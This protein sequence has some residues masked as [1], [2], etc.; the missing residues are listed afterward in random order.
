[1]TLAAELTDVLFL[2]GRV[3]FAAVLGYLALGNLLD[4]EGT[5]GYA[6]SKGA[7]FPSISVPLSSGLVVIGAMSILVGAYPLVGGLIIGG[8]LTI[9]T[10]IMHDFWN[11]DGMDRQT[12]QISFLKNVGL[13]GGALLLASLASTDWPYAL[14]IGL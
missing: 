13:A 5:V 4:L 11:A 9:I 8:F 6:Q 12:E 7:P 2:V 1:M 10:P 3:L 14:G